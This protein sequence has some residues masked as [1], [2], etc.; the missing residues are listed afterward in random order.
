MK[1]LNHFVAFSAIH[2]EINYG[3]SARLPPLVFVDLSDPC[4]WPTPLLV[5]ASMH[6][7]REYAS[8]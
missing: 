1:V 7:L 4:Y 2:T 8:K 5:R 3:R 6:V